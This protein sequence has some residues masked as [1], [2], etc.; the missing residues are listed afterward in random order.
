MQQGDVYE[1]YTVS[2]VTDSI[3]AALAC[4]PEVKY[5]GESES[6]LQ[7][8]DGWLRCSFS[9]PQNKIIY[10]RWSLGRHAGRLCRKCCTC[11]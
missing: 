1:G 10:V 6:I 8:E 11:W 4:K 7:S 2:M 3:E 5:E 9:H